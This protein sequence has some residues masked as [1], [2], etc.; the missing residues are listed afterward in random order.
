M[1]ANEFTARMARLTAP[2]F[3]AVAAALRAEHETADGEVA[4]WRATMA[5]NASLRRQRRTREAGLA[6]HHAAAAVLESA[7]ECGLLDAERTT[8]I[9]VARAAAEV[10]RAL[11][12]G[13][14]PGL[15]SATGGVLFVPFGPYLQ[16]PALS[17]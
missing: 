3:V 7:R 8:A 10:A 14:L 12:A 11:I 1:Q 13:Q 5:V 9:A 15:P 17:A 4:W 6:A 16:P 2:D